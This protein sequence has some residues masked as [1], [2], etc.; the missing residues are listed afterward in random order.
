MDDQLI[1]FDALPVQVLHIDGKEF[2]TVTAQLVILQVSHPGETPQVTI[3][4]LSVVSE[5]PVPQG[6]HEFAALTGQGRFDF[7]G[8]PLDPGS[9]VQVGGRRLP[10]SLV[11]PT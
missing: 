1:K 2:A 10:L 3:N 9:T 11:Q 6:S 4:E 5:E 7:T 8:A